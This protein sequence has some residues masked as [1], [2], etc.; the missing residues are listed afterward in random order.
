[1]GGKVPELVSIWGSVGRSVP[2]IFGAQRKSTRAFAYTCTKLE[3]DSRA[4]R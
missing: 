3:L 4:R 2:E 1:M